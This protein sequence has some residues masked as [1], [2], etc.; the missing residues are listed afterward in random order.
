MGNLNLKLL[1]KMTYVFKLADPPVCWTGLTEFSEKTC[2]TAADPMTLP[3]TMTNLKFDTKWY[4]A[5]CADKTFTVHTGADEAAAKA[6]P[7]MIVPYTAAKGVVGC[8]PWAAAA[9]AAT[10]AVFFKMTPLDG[11]LQPPMVMQRRMRPPLVP[12]P[13]LLLSLPVPSLLPP[14]SSE[15]T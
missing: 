3:K 9:D 2:A 14:P 10:A 12:H 15:H 13:W 1:L 6:A 11:L 4:L 5:A 7:A 8:T